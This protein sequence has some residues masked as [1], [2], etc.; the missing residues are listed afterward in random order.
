MDAVTGV[1]LCAI[2]LPI[3]L[4]KDRMPVGLQ[5]IAPAWAEGKLLAI[6]LAA[7]RVLGTATERLGIP[8]LLS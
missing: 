3:G 8:P 1:G 7:E 5:L 4:D 2:T 6:T